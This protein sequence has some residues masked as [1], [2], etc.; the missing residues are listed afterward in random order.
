MKRSLVLLAVVGCASS[1]P[2]PDVRFENAPAV[3][4]VNDRRDV[5]KTPQ[6]AREQVRQLKAAG[7]DAVKFIVE[8]LHWHGRDVPVMSRDVMRAII[9]EAHALELKAYAHAPGLQHAK[10]VLRAGGDGLVHSV[11]DAP[12][13]DDFIELMRKNRASYTTTLSLFAAFTDIEAWM[14]RLDALDHRRVIPRAVYA[15]YRSPEGARRYYEVF[16]TVASGVPL[17]VRHNLRAVADAGLLVVAGT[18]TNVSGVLMGISSQMELLLLVEAGLTPAEALRAATINAARM[19]GREAEQGTVDAG[20]LA[21][22]VVL[23]ADP[24][25]DIRNVTRLHRVVKDGVIFDPGKLL[26]GG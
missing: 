1:P 17:N 9:D 10:D 11:V 24:L 13:D 23:D 16:K 3:E 15:R 20:K 19:L 5:P 12:V 8:D 22:L 2:I 6:E 26:A 18:D 7:V 21:D 14:Q 25:V 4:V